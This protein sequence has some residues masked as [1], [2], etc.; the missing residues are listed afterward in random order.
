[1][2]E[3]NFLIYF[4]ALDVNADDDAVHRITPFVC[5]LLLNFDF[6]HCSLICRC[7]FPKLNLF[8]YFP[9]SD[10]SIF[11]SAQQNGTQE[12]IKH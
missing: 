7:S 11:I 4:W 2:V 12:F 5:A 9:S 1:M 8:L 10:S 6:I 3:R